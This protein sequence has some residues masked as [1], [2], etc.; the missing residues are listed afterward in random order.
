MLNADF[1]LSF[2]TIFTTSVAVE[3]TVLL[4]TTAP[5]LQGYNNLS[6]QSANMHVPPFPPSFPRALSVHHRL[7]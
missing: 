3:S 6:S 4:A 1:E 2:P 5:H 7:Q